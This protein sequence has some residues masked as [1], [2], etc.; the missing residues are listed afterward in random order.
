MAI[1][2]RPGENQPVGGL[3]PLH[4]GAPILEAPRFG[5]GS[6]R[7]GPAQPISG[8]RPYIIR[9]LVYLALV[10]AGG[11]A[12]LYF[13]FDR[14][15][16]AFNHN[17]VLNGAIFFVFALGI[18]YILREAFTLVGSASWANEVAQSKVD[19]RTGVSSPPRLMA[20]LGSVL[21]AKRLSAPLVTSLLD[22]LGSR[23]GEARETARYI[24]GL[25]VFLGLLG[26]FWGLLGTINAVAEVIGQLDPQ[27]G[28][29]SV[30]F[31]DLT[32]GLRAPLDGMGTAFSTSLFGLAAS[33]L[34]GFLDLQAGQ[35]QNRFYNDL[36]EWL[37]ENVGHADLL[38]DL[39][40]GG[41]SG[42]NMPAYINALL[43]KSAESLDALSGVI[44]GQH[45]AQLRSHQ[46]VTT[47]S[48]Q[49]TTLID[50]MRVEQEV[51][52]RMAENQA[53]AS[54]GMDEVTR[55]HIRNTDTHLARLVD[56][57]AAARGQFIGE[58][59]EEIRLVSRTIAAAAE[60]RDTAN[61]SSAPA[62]GDTDLGGGRAR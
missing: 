18:A 17:L 43:R 51:L 57:I 29:I 32:R 12:A 2:V 56:D 48:N 28:D 58:L 39:A 36:E 47:L 9:M 46:A 41:A 23:L 11:G 25:L 31:G 1:D 15:A 45:E 24:I 44:A 3:P 5:A 49:L 55:G 19:G 62:A 27:T 26:T 42:Q 22:G 35:A 50:Q 7:S 21:G 52:K 37:T 34:L 59:R 40:A 14:L 10:A 54:D 33:I 30:L 4:Q 53:A 38:D 6:G 8:P 20:P 61:D 13:Q 60:N 16:T